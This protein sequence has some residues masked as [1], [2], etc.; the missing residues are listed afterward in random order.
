MRSN[1]ILPATLLATLAACADDSAEEVPGSTDTN[2]LTYFRDA[3]PVIDARC[4]TCHQMGEIGPFPLTSHEEV[5]A[6]AGAVRASIERGTMPPWQPSDACNTYAENIDL[7]DD[8]KQLLLDWLDAGAPAGDPA[9]AL[10][11]PTVEDAFRADLSL[12]LPE[13]Y[14]PT[15]EPDDYRCQLIP[16]PSTETQYVTGLR[17][18]PEQRS[19]VHHVIVF[20][21]E[22]EEVAQF[23]AFDADEA[24]PGYT[25]YG[26][27]RGSESGGTL[28]G[29]DPVQLLAALQRLGI[30]LADLQ[31]GNVTEAQLGQLLAELGDGSVAGF[32]T[33]G[34]WVP[35]IPNAPLPAGTGIRV[36]PGSML[37]AQFHY[38]T[39]TSAPV[40]DQSVI[41]IS[42]TSAVER[43]ATTLPAV[44]LGWISD[45]FVGEP[46]SI[47]A[48]AA[49]VE[50]STEIAFDSIFFASARQTLG[51]AEDAPLVIH[52]ANHHMHQLGT[53][54][55]TEVRHA[56]GSST[57][58]LDIPDW[59][60]D[61][62]GS[63]TLAAP[64][65]IRPGDTIWM[66][67]TWD[68]SMANQPIID[69][70]VRDPV[71]VAWGEGTSDE[72]CLGS[73]YVTGE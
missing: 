19:I 2:A 22:P 17:V 52:N 70:Q 16:W 62:Q 25:C 10:P 35:G 60:F 5:M 20:L 29:V 68:N 37:V 42:L 33:I 18:T 47:P 39:L 46:M 38:N 13:P 55:R 3:K 23:Q 21:A 69:G 15:R 49:K 26:G 63:Y 45:G 72:M 32:R 67:C 54:Q 71:D 24:G 27:P 73:F 48:G 12:Q 51:L 7:A 61:W 14:T 1:F 11:P 30:T 66:G 56:D 44:D 43:E 59:D 34:S 50:H 41:E 4:A 53:Q 64:I 40:S 65:T 9:D 31:A 8:E 36:E 6:F 28:D 57:C 58:V